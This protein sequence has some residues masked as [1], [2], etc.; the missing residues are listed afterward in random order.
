LTT[1]RSSRQNAQS[2][3][4]DRYPGYRG[5]RQAASLSGLSRSD[6]VHW[7]KAALIA[8]QPSGRERGM[9]GH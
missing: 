2:A 6:L 7:H 5:R 1:P 9:T 4:D 3:I 8:L